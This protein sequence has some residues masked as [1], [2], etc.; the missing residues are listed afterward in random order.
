MSE[1]YIK[2]LKKVALLIPVIL[3]F[4]I[5]KNYATDEFY[6]D[7]EEIIKQNT[8]VKYKEELMIEENDIE[9][10]TKYVENDELP[11]GLIVVR[12]QGREGSSKKITVKKYENE[13]L[14][15]EEVK[16]EIKMGVPV[17]KVVE[18]GVGKEKY[19]YKP[20]KGDYVNVFGTNV[21]LY[22]EP[23]RDS[24]KGKSV[25]IGAKVRILEILDNWYKV[26]FGKNQGYVEA[27]CTYSDDF[28]NP[29]SLSK[30]ELTKNLDFNMDLSKKSNLT[31]EQFQKILS[32]EKYD[33]KGVMAANAEYF[34]YAEQQYG[35]NGVFLA[36]VAVHESNWGQSKIA[37]DKKNLFGYGASDSNPYGNAGTFA[38]YAEGIDLVARVFVKY[39]INA[40]GTIIYDGTEASGKYHNGSNLSGVN[41]KY[42][43]DKNWANGVYKWMKIL[44]GSL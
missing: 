13:N 16:N 3:S 28:L 17:N 37:N 18:I 44:Y 5:T 39:Y 22:S 24:E 11:T 15:S 21:Y 26:E 43:S 9:Y 40:P 31:L 8:E 42:A 38:T 20:R 6:I 4:L 33:K 14:I 30:N 25:T 7:A 35:L 12:I 27:I 41:V 2:M 23:S 19:N 10:T 34:Y 36:A 29:E 1:F 32:N